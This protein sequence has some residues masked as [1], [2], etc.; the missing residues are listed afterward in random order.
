MSQIPRTFAVI[1]PVV[2]TAAML[3][4]SSVPEPGP[5]D[6]TAWVSGTPYVVGNTV[7]LASTHRIYTCTASTSAP[8]TT[9]PNL[10]TAHWADTE[11]VQRWK[12]FDPLKTT[13]T[14]H[15]SPMVVEVATGQRCNAWF[16]GGVAA[17]S[18]TVEQFDGASLVYSRAIPMTRRSTRSWSDYFFGTFDPISAAMDMGMVLISGSTVRFTFTSATGTVS[19]GKVVVGRSIQIGAAEAGVEV[20]A[21]N[22]SRIDR[23]DIDGTA[24]LV[25]RR[26]VPNTS[27]TVYFNPEDT[28]ILLALRDRLNAVPAVWSALGTGYTHN[29]FNALKVYGIYTRFRISATSTNVGRLSLDLEEL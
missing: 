6:P 3:V 11:A 15:T 23:S 17:D 7:R 4:S 29:Y 5:A 19:V 10:D 8:H 21:E 16:V 24:T 12:M 13:P 28:D 14:A 18:L 26:N 1:P 9:A 25:P 22:F 27:Q 20:D 2:I